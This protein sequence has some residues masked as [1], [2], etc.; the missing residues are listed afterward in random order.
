M[1]TEGT[2]MTGVGSVQEGT[3]D[4]GVRTHGYSKLPVYLESNMQRPQFMKDEGRA[5]EYRWFL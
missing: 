3:M 4:R 1:R 5:V 2:P